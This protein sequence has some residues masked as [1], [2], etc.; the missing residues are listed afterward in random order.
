[1]FLFWLLTLIVVVVTFFRFPALRRHV[2]VVKAALLLALRLIAIVVALLLTFPIAFSAT[3]KVEYPARVAILID[4]SQSADTPQ[5]TKVLTA[6]GQALGDRADAVT[7]WQFSDDVKSVPLT[8]MTQPAHGMASRLSDAVIRIAETVRPDTLVIIAD[9]QDTEPQPCERIIATLLRSATR[10]VAI[11]LSS[12]LPPNL[13]ISASPIRTALFAGEEAAVTVGVQGQNLQ[14]ATTAQIHIWEGRRLVQRLAISLQPSTISLHQL[15]VRLR[16]TKAGWHRYRIEV[17]P[18]KGERWTA[19]NTAEASVWQ[20]LTKLRVLL[21]CGNPTFEFKFVKQNVEAEPNFEWAA[22]AS[23]PDGIRYQQGTPTL[24]P[25]SLQRLQPFHVIIALAPTPADL[26]KAEVGAICQFV[27]K[28]GGLL[29]TLNNVSVLTQGWRLFVSAPLQLTLLPSPITLTPVTDDLLGERLSKLPTVDAAWTIEESIRQKAVGSR[30]ATAVEA[31]GKAV[32]A[33]WQEGL[34]KVALFSTDGT[35][36]W[37][38]D[39]ARR[40]E[41]PTVHHL[42]WRTIIRFL[43][44]PQ[45]D[46]GQKAKGE[47]LMELSTPRPPPDE[48][49]ELPNPKRL[50]RWAEAT[51]GMVLTPDNVATWVD[52]ISWTKSVTVTDT[53]P[54]SAN[55]L[56]YLVL[57]TALILEWWFVRRSGLL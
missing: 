4:A 48:W 14:K 31:N 41:P 30:I 49:T 5:R 54:F 25:V 56:S 12:S 27:Q 38:M 3:R 35:W 40:G 37:V 6:L 16:P 9:G 34:G 28:G 47:N 52:K 50:R 46:E 55:P 26:S 7:V 17:T 45:K 8:Q 29:V 11:P 44:D 20:A 15:T 13:Q 33:W 19:D 2:G 32:L 21:V 23:L 22:I 43:A 10:L 1:M 24:L 53:R 42:F 39:A 36:Q 57:L 51:K 18:L